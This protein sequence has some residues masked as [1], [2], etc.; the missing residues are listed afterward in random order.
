VAWRPTPRL[1]T[2]KVEAGQRTLECDSGKSPLRLGKPPVEAYG[3][4]DLGPYAQSAR[5]DHHAGRLAGKR[6]LI[7]GG[8]GA[9]S[10][11]RPCLQARREGCYIALLDV[12]LLEASLMPRSCIGVS[13]LVPSSA[14]SIGR[15]R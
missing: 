15:R 12:D 1:V 5:M 7:T 11:P 6:A 2:D 9:A 14:T 3:F 4:C 13:P 8:G 10:G